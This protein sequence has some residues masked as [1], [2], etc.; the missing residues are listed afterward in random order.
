MSKSKIYI[1][2]LI[3]VIFLTYMP[4]L[5][6]G[7]V[8][9][10]KILMSSPIIQRASLPRV[11][12]ASIK[13]I[14]GAKH[15]NYWRPLA[16]VSV[17]LEHKLYGKRPLFYKIDQMLLHF[18]TA[19]LVWLVSRRVLRE[20]FAVPGGRAET[21]AYLVALMWAAHPSHCEV[22]ATVSGRY[23]V[24]AGIFVIIAFY[25]FLRAEEEENLRRQEFIIAAAGGVYLLGLFSKEAAAPLPIFLLTLLL[26]PQFSKKTILKTAGFMLVVFF[27]LYFPIRQSILG[28]TGQIFRH[29]HFWGGL[30]NTPYLLAKYLQLLIVP[31]FP[32]PVYYIDIFTIALDLR[33]ILSWIIFVPFA[34]I[35]VYSLIKRTAE[36]FGFVWYLAFIAPVMGIFYVAGTIVAERFLYIPSVGFF[37]ALVCYLER[38]YLKHTLAKILLGIYLLSWMITGFVYI[39]TAWTTQRKIAEYTMKYCPNTEVGYLLGAVDAIKSGEPERAIEYLRR[40]AVQVGIY[41]DDFC[42]PMAVAQTMIG[43]TDS[44]IY[45]YRRGLAAKPDDPQFHNNLGVLLLDRGMADSA[46]IHFESALR[47]D[48]TYVPAYKSLIRYYLLRGDTTSAERVYGVMQRIISQQVDISGAKKLQK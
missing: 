42:R 6:G 1:A 45:W 25:L 46:R 5:W 17:W 27:A 44:A 22:V 36:G 48:S 41:S 30:F 2:T 3:F 40:C 20:K 35:V 13:D 28:D 11:V 8:F 31:Y 33:T 34:V 18:L 19:L 26:F 4:S 43:D 16:V 38:R 21:L 10:D 14:L 47:A 24:L 29:Q 9:D 32:R 7:F 15:Q 39:N 12:F 23:D 37:V